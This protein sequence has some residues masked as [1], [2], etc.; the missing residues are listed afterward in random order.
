[1]ERLFDSFSF[2][3]LWTPEIIVVLLGI[4]FFFYWITVKWRHKFIGAE[5]VPLHQKIYFGLALISL[6]L[7]LGSP[8]YT[9]GH[10]IFTLHMTQMVLVYYVAIPLLI[11]AIPKWLLYSVLH[12]W[13]RKSL[14]SYRILMSPIMGLIGFN[15]LFSIYHLPLVFDFMMQAS[16]LPNFYQAVLFAGAW[17]MWWHILDPAPIEDFYLSDL[18]R[19]GYIFLNG[20]LITPACALMIF[21]GSPMYETYTNPNM[22]MHGGDVA[23]SFLSDYRDQQLAGIVMKICQEII[24]GFAM[25]YVFKQWVSKEKQQDGELTI[26]DI[27]TK[28]Y[29]IKPK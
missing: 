8:L 24:F 23:L 15:T 3:T 18:R 12:K 20:I 19:I 14:R 9:A 17:L 7:G 4:A 2:W 1:M 13:K 16:V 10:S 22:M 5:D 29:E 6:Y 26:S 11:L 25:G 27:P 28:S 21:A